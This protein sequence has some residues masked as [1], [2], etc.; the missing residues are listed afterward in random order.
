L[1]RAM[2]ILFGFSYDNA[3]AETAKQ[4]ILWNDGETKN[5]NTPPPFLAASDSRFFMYMQF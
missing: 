3:A 2:M 4:P 5:T 1:A